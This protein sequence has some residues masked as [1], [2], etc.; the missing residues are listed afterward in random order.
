MDGIQ[1]T[2]AYGLDSFG[3]NQTLLAQDPKQLEQLKTSC[4]CE[5]K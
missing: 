3:S 5:T 1:E 2:S 4:C